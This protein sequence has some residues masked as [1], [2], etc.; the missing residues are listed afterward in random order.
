MFK[1]NNQ[2]QVAEEAIEVTDQQD[3]DKVNVNASAPSA[4]IVADKKDYLNDDIFS[5]IKT[6]DIAELIEKEAESK[7]SSELES[8]YSNT[9]GYISEH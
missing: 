1:E 2:E 5:D 3:T 8:Q 4:D 7:I 9:F 6:V